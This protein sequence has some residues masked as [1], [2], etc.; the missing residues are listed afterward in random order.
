MSSLGAVRELFASYSPKE[1]LKRLAALQLV[2]RN[3]DHLFRLEAAASAVAALPERDAPIPSNRQWQALLN[4]GTVG[5]GEL[6]SQEDPFVGPFAEE[7]VFYGGSFVVLPGLGED[8]TF[9]LNRLLR[10]IFRRRLGNSNYRRS[11]HDLVRG[12]LE[13]SDVVTERGRIDRGTKAQDSTGRVHFPSQADIAVFE[14]AVE[15]D[16]SSFQEI[17]ADAGVSARSLDSLTMSGGDGTLPEDPNEAS[18]LRRPIVQFQDSMIVAA[19]CGLLSALRNAIIAV[20]LEIGLQSELA[21]AFAEDC[22][23]VAHLALSFLKHSRE[24]FP[25]LPA[26]GVQGLHEAIFRFD[27]DKFL[28]VQLLADSLDGYDPNQ[29][30]GKWALPADTSAL[31]DQRVLEV[32]STVLRSEVVTE[33]MTATLVQGLG[34]YWG[35]S[36][37]HNLSSVASLRLAMS[38][39]DLETVCLLEAPDPLALWNFA[40]AAHKLREETEVIRFGFLDEFQMYRLRDYGFYFSDDARPNLISIVPEGGDL[41]NEVLDLFDFHGVSSCDGLSMEDV[42]LL[43]QDA[44]VPIYVPWPVPGPKLKLTVESFPVVVWLEGEASSNPSLRRIHSL[45]VD[46][47]AYWMWQIADEVTASIDFNSHDLECIAVKIYVLGGDQW[48][49]EEIP[50]TKERPSVLPYRVQ[51][52]DALSID[53]PASLIPML[54]SHNN[55]ADRVV[56]RTLLLGFRELLQDP[57]ISLSN[58][59]VERILEARAPLGRKKKAFILP[60]DA[61]P[62]LHPT[63]IDWSPR[64]SRAEVN[65]VLDEVGRALAAS[66]DDDQGARASELL[67]DAVSQLFETIKEE[68]ATLAPTG[69]LEWLVGHHEQI[70]H[71]RSTERFETPTR[72]ACFSDIETMA[73]KL[74]KEIPETNETALASRFL[75]EYVA[76]SPP[77]GL[78]PI[79]LAVYERLLVACSTLIGWGVL[80][81][82]VYFGLDEPDVSILR[83]GRLGIGGSRFAAARDQFLVEH[84]RAEVERRI[85]N[86]ERHWHEKNEGHPPAEFLEFEQATIAEFGFPIRTVT[87]VLGEVF[88]FGVRTEGEAKVVEAAALAETVSSELG[89]DV[90]ATH[91]LLERFTLSRRPDFL[92]PPPPYSRADI[93]PWRFSRPL[94]YVHRP[95]ISRAN[96]EGKEELVFGNRHLFQSLNNFIGMVISGRYQPTTLPLKQWVSKHKNESA[97]AFNRD[98]ARL[99]ES[100]EWEVRTKIDKFNGKRLARDNGEDLGDVDVLAASSRRREILAIETKDLAAA[101]TAAEMKSEIDAL[102]RSTPSTMSLH[103][104]RVAW[105]RSHLA[106]VLAELGLPEGRYKVSPMVVVD[107]E[108]VTPFLESPVIPVSTYQSMKRDLQVV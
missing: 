61:S 37:D 31:L 34:R 12:T 56:V 80:S 87:D 98:V 8:V 71:R 64:I 74:R 9:V 48:I 49:G 95:L 86:F 93:Y 39:S 76:A 79:N 7:I 55:E 82:L 10:S 78:N 69:L 2:T 29:A 6:R 51:P 45:M 23:Q 99:F 84:A 36:V 24:E 11:I 100:S 107:I 63:S 32:E 4:E 1:C 47:V 15:F 25:S 40:R 94:S 102:I 38:A 97:D 52:H 18:L 92:N 105:L 33:V 35:L 90:S 104:E 96:L 27:R 46:M 14:S 16:D 88:N 91:T 22:F 53:F 66:H 44:S 26:P 41:R 3:A 62:D 28:Y 72:L 67:N 60:K 108:S 101:R 77:T 5:T 57:E 21:A 17:L 70:V 13:L 54:A 73:E 43:Y 19:P 85:T 20:S 83:S 89:I 65:F 68:I 42:A 50:T 103:R 58:D 59:N 81:D 106:D 75:V 30:F